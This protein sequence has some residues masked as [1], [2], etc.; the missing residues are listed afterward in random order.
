M[1]PHRPANLVM[2][3]LGLGA[4]ALAWRLGVLTL[5]LTDPAVGLHVDEAQYWDWSRVLQGGYY[6]KP[7][8]IAALIAASTALAGDTVIGVRWLAMATHVAA[9]LALAGLAHDMA[10]ASVDPADPQRPRRAALWAALIGLSN[11]IAGLLGL[12]ATTD[13]PLLLTWTL[14]AWA[15]W[16]ALLHDRWPHWLAFGLAL[17]AGLLSKY[18]MA[19]WLPM[20]AVL[21]WVRRPASGRP[22]APGG[23]ALALGLAGLM[24]MPNLLWNAAAG[25]P[26]WQ[27]TA[28]ITVQ[29]SR[30]ADH[31]AL[32]SLAE[33][34]GGQWLMSG[35]LWL[36]LW[37]WQRR[38]VGPA[39]A[40][41]VAG[42]PWLLVLTLPLLGIGALQALHAK[43][44][45]NWT[46][47]VMQGVVLAL[48]LWLAP[49]GRTS[50]RRLAAGVVCLHLLLVTA[51]P[52]IG[53]VARWLDGPQA[54]PPRTLDLWA[55]MRGWTPAFA[56][57]RP[58][59]ATQPA[60]AVLIGTDRTL[61][62]HGRY[63]WRDL[64]WRWHAWRPDPGRAPIDHYQLT[65]G[66]PADRP[67]AD[68]DRPLLIVTEGATLPAGWLPDLVAPQRLADVQVAQGAGHPLQLTLWRSRW[69]TR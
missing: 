43:A 58:V 68:R 57:L 61:I 41:P 20:A 21:L 31:P 53:T 25:W 35:P 18:T 60:N 12:S 52:L 4:L 19:V 69:R 54:L 50:L 65:A 37:L 27:H 3:L 6:S 11:P 32:V 46:T 56:A 64:P 1:T 48:A 39:T 55:R 40:W 66:W 5:V 59:L 38:R 15:L 17:G 23:P 62:A 42:H 24:M 9:V 63:A 28:E 30:D 34:L 22:I 47:P 33:W 7:P 26:T 44:Q 29:A 36:P 45:I 51:L 14:A 2:T 49:A 13:A 10:T 16:R 67:P 8:G